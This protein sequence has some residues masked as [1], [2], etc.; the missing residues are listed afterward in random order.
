MTYDPRT[1]WML[2][3]ALVL[4]AAGG[5][6][7]AAMGLGDLRAKPKGKK[8]RVYIAGK[9]DAK[10]GALY[11]FHLDLA[12]GAL[13]PVGVTGGLPNPSFIAIAPGG[14]FLYTADEVYSFQRKPTGTVSAFAIDPKTGDLTFLNQRESGGAG[15]CYV[16]VD[17][18]GKVLLAANY[19]GGSVCSIPIGA[20]GKLGKPA[21][22]IQ[23]EGKGAD[24][25]RQ[26]GSHAHS[27]NV[28]PTNAFAIAADL[29]L[30][31]LLV[32]RLDTSKGTLTPSD[33]PF[34]ALA[35][36]SG[37]RHLA[38][39][40]NGKLAYVINELN[41]TVT[42]LRYA[43]GKL[44]TVQTISTLPE[45]ASSK[46]STAEVAV[47]P[48][49]KFLYG[50]NRGHD[51]IAVFAIDAGTGK[52]TPV[53]YESVRGNWPRHFRIDPT[54]AFL[55]VA[56]RHTDNVV[57]F[58]IDARTG[59]LSPTGHEAKVPAAICVKFLEPK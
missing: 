36:G 20:D 7:A 1:C 56:N 21:S 41:S 30:D 58:R 13:E 47:H 53:E 26:K 52:L 16:A 46:N 9:T 40:P 32:Y 18:A 23:H 4:C 2:L 55:L 15:P 8:L 42:A 54:G 37:P 22:V 39:H 38:F 14:R 50:S 12:S 57:V 5:S 17:A 31:K 35:P 51:S 29:G 6:Q 3:G 27:I 28:D 11:R 43:A 10:K 19:G 33:P 49:G 34:A 45:G 59:K 48:S 24:P 25:K 44:D